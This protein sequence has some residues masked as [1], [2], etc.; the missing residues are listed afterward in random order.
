[1][2]L[3]R[4]TLLPALAL[5]LLVLLVSCSSTGSSSSSGNITI[6]V[7]AD[8]VEDQ[9]VATLWYDSAASTPADNEA[10]SEELEEKVLQ[11]DGV[12]VIQSVCSNDRISVQVTVAEGQDRERVFD[13]LRALALRFEAEHPELQPEAR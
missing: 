10:L 9:D 11:L 6:G 13:E 12:K 8:G 5:S 2:K 3:E 4:T 1:M 7:T